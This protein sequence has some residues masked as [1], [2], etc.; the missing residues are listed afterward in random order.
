MSAVDYDARMA[1]RRW[2][3]RPVIRRWMIGVEDH[4][5]LDGQWMHATRYLLFGLSRT[6]QVDF[7][8]TYYD[9]CHHSLWLGWLFLSWSRCDCCNCMPCGQDECSTCGWL[10]W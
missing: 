2:R 10:P 6:W 7:Y 3:W 8:H 5:F 9:G 1:A 4:V